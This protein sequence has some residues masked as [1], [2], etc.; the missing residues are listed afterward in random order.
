MLLVEIA[1][2]NFHAPVEAF[3]TN[4][5]VHVRGSYAIQRVDVAGRG[6]WI[7]QKREYGQYDRS[8][9]KSLRAL[10]TTPEAFDTG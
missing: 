10:V 3:R 7:H 2:L 1:S 8:G 6:R 4:R 9:T 5:D